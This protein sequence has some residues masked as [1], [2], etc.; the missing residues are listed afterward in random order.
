MVKGTGTIGAWL[1]ALLAM[2]AV[3]LPR[4]GHAQ[5]TTGGVD[6][7]AGLDVENPALGDRVRFAVRVDGARG[8]SLQPPDFGKV[9]AFQVEGAP[10]T[11]SEQS[12]INGVVRLSQTWTWTLT[13]VKPGKF[14]IPSTSYTI[15]ERTYTTDAIP[16]EVRDTGDSRILSAKTDYAEINRQLEGRYFLW[17]ELPS[18]VWS[19][20]VVPVE[21]YLFRSPELP[22]PIALGVDDPKPGQDFIFLRKNDLWESGAGLAWEKAEFEG[23]RME[24]AL[25]SRQ[26][27]VP[28]KGG[29]ATLN[30]PT[31]YVRLPTKNR[32]AGGFDEDFGFLQPR[33]LQ[34]VL[35][36]REKTAEIK[37]LPPAPAGAI[38][39]VIGD[40][41]VVAAVDRNEAP[42][43]DPVTL[44]IGLEGE[45]N[46]SSIS[47]PKL[48]DIAGFLPVDTTSDEKMFERRGALVTRRTFQ[49]ILQA[50]TAGLQTIPA[51]AIAVFD[52]KAGT[53]SLKKTSAF[54]VD[55]KPTQ[56]S[57]IAIETSPKTGEDA[58]AGDPAPN[59]GSARRV[60]EDVDWI[61]KA[62][63]RHQDA[64]G[65]SRSVF[66][67]W[68]FWALQAV[69]PL[70]ALVLG[71]ASIRSRSVDRSSTSYRAREW[72]KQAEAALREARGNLT[73]A[74]KGDFYASLSRG[75]MS[76]AASILAR[77]P[78]G[79]T[80]DEAV[81]GLKSAGVDQET[82][83]RF[84]RVSTQA[85]EM[86]F[87]PLTDSQDRR[88]SDLDE[89][90]AVLVQLARGG[91]RA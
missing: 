39:E 25:I 28:T 67:L 3:V 42:Q 33:S 55:V 2:V 41:K 87:S 29:T 75:I 70:V 31:F 76:G 66:S 71:G 82:L 79:L 48:P 43:L 13:A 64:R 65:T 77:P 32:G 57:A 35:R 8:G 4:N 38:L 15:G 56:T 69:P 16:G 91:T 53:W 88:K 74:K 11:M 68:W 27:Y 86:R 89:A 12:I 40:V 21:V 83:A 81:D 23:M 59:R 22:A 63:L 19:R 46:L 9:P 60:G 52:T 85:E 78:L 1:L 5:E 14:V 44:T 62:P 7:T 49:L 61:D 26:W 18:T 80:I 58:A 37:P 24:R 72:K 20:Q 90:E 51:L 6:I 47:P 54:Q 17:A 34:A 30:L 36:S 73:A 84:R 45:A 50:R 10:A